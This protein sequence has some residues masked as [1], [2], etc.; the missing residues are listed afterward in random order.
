MPEKS[1]RLFPESASTFA[2]SVD[3]L[4]LYLLLLS[5]FFAVLIAFLVIYFAVKYR[6]RGP[7]IPKAADEHSIG[8]MLLEIVWSVI[9]LGLSMII[10]VWGA[11]IMFTE[12]RP[13]ADSLDVYVTG[14]QWM[15]K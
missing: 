9:P 4:Y 1:F 2:G 10:F 14:K 8:G 11:V 15:W 3:G 6:Y 7:A 12:S 13:P 5:A